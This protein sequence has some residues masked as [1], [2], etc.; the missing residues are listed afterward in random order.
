MAAFSSGRDPRDL[1]IEP[2][3][4]PFSLYFWRKDLFGVLFC[5]GTNSPS[6]HTVLKIPAIAECRGIGSSFPEG[7]RANVCGVC[8]EG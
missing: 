3:V 1:G 8:G 4:C 6:H 5:F 2:V 7:A